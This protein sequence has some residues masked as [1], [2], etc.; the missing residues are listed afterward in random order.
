[1]GQD[2]SQ[3]SA[4][5]RHI[6]DPESQADVG[7]WSERLGVDEAKLRELISRVGPDVQDLRRVLG[8]YTPGS[9]RR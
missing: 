3:E 7:F 5:E 6:I 8:E 2:P 9:S 4:G 1:M